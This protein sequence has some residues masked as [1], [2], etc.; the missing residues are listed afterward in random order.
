MADSAELVEQAPVQ[1]RDLLLRL[2]LYFEAFEQRLRQGE[3]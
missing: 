1:D 3:G 2:S